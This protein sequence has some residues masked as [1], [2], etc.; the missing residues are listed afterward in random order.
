[1]N[2]MQKCEDLLLAMYINICIYPEIIKSVHSSN[3]FLK[4][5]KTKKYLDN[6]LI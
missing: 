5:L 6:V 2:Y 3:T 1:M 4:K